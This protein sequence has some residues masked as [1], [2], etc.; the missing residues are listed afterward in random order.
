MNTEMTELEILDAYS[1]MDFARL[2][3]YLMGRVA[4]CDNTEEAVTKELDAFMNL[5]HSH[6]LGWC[7][8]VDPISVL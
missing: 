8:V 7:F 6:E 5:I 3:L 1:A 4:I 2:T